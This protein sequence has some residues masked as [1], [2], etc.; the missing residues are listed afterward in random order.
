MCNAKG[1]FLPKLRFGNEATGL[2]YLKTSRVEC[3]K[4]VE[5]PAW[6]CLKQLSKSPKCQHVPK[7]IGDGNRQAVRIITA[8]MAPGEE[9]KTSHALKPSQGFERRA[10]D[11][12]GCRKGFGCGVW[13]SGSGPNSGSGEGGGVY[14]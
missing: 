13:G 1:L 10:W 12:G 7:H 3:Q 4:M 5:P 2:V 11:V 9:K 14:V 6:P 8:L